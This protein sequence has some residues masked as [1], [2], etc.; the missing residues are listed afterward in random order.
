MDST[1]IKQASELIRTVENLLFDLP[2]NWQEEAAEKDIDMLHVAN[3]L[4]EIAEFLEDK[5]EYFYVISWETREVF[6]KWE[7]LAVAKRWCRG[8]G[9]TGEDNPGLTGYPPI[10]YVANKAGECVYNPRFG[11]NIRADVGSLINAQ[12]SNHF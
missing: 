7:K 3:T 12:P 9:H 10:A 8:M 6:S 4:D 2:L 1:Q 5:I 11:K